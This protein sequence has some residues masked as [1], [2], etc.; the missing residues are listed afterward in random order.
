VIELNYT[1]DDAAIKN[2]IHEAEASSRRSSFTRPWS[3]DPR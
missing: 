1:L 2:L 3:S